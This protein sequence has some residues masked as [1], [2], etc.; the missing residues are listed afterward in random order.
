M[1]LTDIDQWNKIVEL[2]GTPTREFT[3]RLQPMVRNYVD[4]RPRHQPHTW[5]ELFPDELF[6]EA[7]SSTEPNK[8]NGKHR[9]WTFFRTKQKIRYL[10][11]T[12]GI[13][14]FHHGTNLEVNLHFPKPV[15]LALLKQAERDAIQFVHMALRSFSSFSEHCRFTSKF[16]P[17]VEKQNGR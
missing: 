15:W 7:R 16:L 1:P 9:P 3:Q 11:I 5:V 13:L 12:T 14:F 4:S 6:Q 17:M 8:L 2:L 10:L